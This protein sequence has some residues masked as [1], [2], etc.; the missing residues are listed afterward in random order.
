MK[1][2]ISNIA[3][4]TVEDEDIADILNKNSI[5]SIDVVPGKYF[6]IPSE[7]R[8]VEILKIKNWWLDRGIKITGM[9][10]L[11]YNT[12]GLNIFASEDI[13]KLMLEHLSDICRI[14]GLLAAKKLAFG[15][16]KNRDRSGLS[17]METMNIAIPFFRKLGD[18]AKGHDVTICLEPNPTC[19]GSNFMTTSSETAKVV[20]EVAHE[21]IKML[22]DTGA[23]TLNE[24]S[25]DLI[26]SKYAFLIG[27]IH[28]SEPNLLPIGDCNTNHRAI[29]K[30]L[31]FHLPYNTVT[32]EM[33]AT[34]DEDHKKSI[35]RALTCGINSYSGT[36]LK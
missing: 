31:E 9:Q 29:A 34:K 18:M 14:G 7:A 12:N 33:V 25:P 24:E 15:S 22:L 19:Y 27:H 36:V 26:I 13:Q 8:E 32:I 11:L 23:I 17:N 20:E 4:D 2:G 28:A 1:L 30:T 10:A 3:W 21:S 5:D 35:Q 16:P 6:P